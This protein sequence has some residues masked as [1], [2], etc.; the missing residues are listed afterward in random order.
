LNRILK[1]KRALGYC[2]KKKKKK[3]KKKKTQKKKKKI[4][5]PRRFFM[6]MGSQD[7]PEK[8]EKK[9]GEVKVAIGAAKEPPM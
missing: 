5:H 8:G 9:K 4:I 6:Q 1:K 3:K 2:E 7:L